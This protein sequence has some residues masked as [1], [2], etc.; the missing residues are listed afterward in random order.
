M[1]FQKK[2]QTSVGQESL[3]EESAIKIRQPLNRK[4]IASLWSMGASCVALATTVVALGVSY[5][6]LKQECDKDCPNDTSQT[7]SAAAPQQF[8]ALGVEM[9]PLNGV[10]TTMDWHY[11]SIYGKEMLSFSNTVE[12]RKDYVSGV[13]EMLD[14]YNVSG[15]CVGFPM[16]RTAM[17]SFEYSS[18]ETAGYGTNVLNEPCQRYHAIRSDNSV[19]YFSRNGKG[20][21]SLEIDGTEYRFHPDRFYPGVIFE[22]KTNHLCKERHIEYDLQTVHVQW[23]WH[24]HPSWH[25]S[26]LNPSSWWHRLKCDACVRGI[27][28]VVGKFNGEMMGNVCVETGPFVSAC[29]YLVRDLENHICG[30]GGCANK[31]CQ[32]VHLC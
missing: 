1:F 16:T 27:D 7:T 22:N 19:F 6:K 25:S 21:C 13:S 29:Q 26:W 12:F 9:Y 20:L 30:G 24:W 5:A 18:L 32:D 23:G 4:L 3:L 28:W 10:N 17:S 14:P 2:P 31:A 8:S 15:T 11:D